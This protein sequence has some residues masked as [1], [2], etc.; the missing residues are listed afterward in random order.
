MFPFLTI[1]INHPILAK[2]S[3]TARWATTLQLKYRSRLNITYLKANNVPLKVDVYTPRKSD[4][5]V[6]TLIYFHGGGWIGGTK[7]GTILQILPYIE[8]GWSVVTV[9]YR[10]RRV[11]PAPAAVED[12]LCA[13]RWVIRNAEKYN[14]NVDKIV[15]SGDSAG[16]HLALTTGMLPASAG[17]DRQCPGK[18]KLK[19]AAIVNWYGITDV[20]DLLEG[21]N[22][23]S[24]AVQWVGSRTDRLQVAQRVSPINYVREDLPPIITIHGDAD[25]IV[26]YSHSFKLHQALEKVEVPNELITISGGGHGNFSEKEMISI[27]DKID[28]FLNNHINN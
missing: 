6:P 11:S 9:Q 26:P 20:A 27:Y 2:L 18:E 7:D 22:Q 10:L 8:K 23:K 16:G 5:P 17:L 28:N 25:T 13:L 14:F 15:V 21:E 24:Y 12:C 4:K 19:V 1:A 3:E